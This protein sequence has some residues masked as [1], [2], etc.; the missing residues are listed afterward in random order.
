MHLGVTGDYM[1]DLKSKQLFSRGDSLGKL[2]EILW[3]RHL[4]K[5]SDK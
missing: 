5:Y 2:L 4:H 3:R 1:Y